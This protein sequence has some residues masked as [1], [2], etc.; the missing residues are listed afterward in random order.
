MSDRIGVGEFATVHRA[1]RRED[2]LTVAVKIFKLDTLANSSLSRI[3]REAELIK[4]AAPHRNLVGFVELIRPARRLNV[5]AIV[6]EFVDGCD[7]LA[8]MRSRDAVV[9]SERE[10]RDLF[11]QL[12]SAVAHLHAAGIVHRDIKLENVL[13]GRADN[14]VKL[15]DFGFARRVNSPE[16]TMTTLCGSPT[17]LAPELAKRREYTLAVDAWACGV[18]LFIMLA[19]A[20]PF[21]ARSETALLRLIARGSFQFDA[22][23]WSTISD[24]AKRLVSSLLTV[25][26]RERATPMSA[27]GHEWFAM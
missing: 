20:P 23:D 15:C 26:V 8:L 10:A 1:V 22:D 9:F 5:R 12:L 14:V 4:L 11:S 21:L 6:M 13:V 2:E 19:G 18:V 7:L 27:L 24:A 25:D 3:E 16:H 17:F